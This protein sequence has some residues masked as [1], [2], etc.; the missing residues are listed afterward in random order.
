[1][2]FRGFLNTVNMRTIR[3]TFSFTIACCLL[4]LTTQGAPSDVI[5]V[6]PG[7][8]RPIEVT[9]AMLSAHLKS[10]PE[11][12][13]TSAVQDIVD[14]ALLAQIA[15]ARGLD[16]DAFVQERR[17]EALAWSY[18]KT[19]FEPSYV[20]Q[21]V[22]EAEA[23]AA[24]KA[25]LSRFVHPEVIKASHILIGSPTSKSIE[26]PKDEALASKARELIARVE[27]A[28][29]TKRPISE[30]DFVAAP[31]SIRKDAEALGFVVRGESLGWFALEDGQ[32]DRGFDPGFR[33]ASFPVAVGEVS[34]V[35]ASPFGWHVVRVS[36]RRAAKNE[37]YEMVQSQV[38]LRLVEQVRKRELD[39]LSARLAMQYPAL[40]DR[41]GILRLLKIEPLIRLDSKRVLPTLEK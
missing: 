3:S 17:R 30:E 25:N 2:V 14:T 37:T 4:P 23:R 10:F 40:T 19:V 33:K 20:S 31:E 36:K 27:A 6:A 24:Y 35:F 22:P 39:K 32:F 16:A 21:A 41:E 28:L 38:K 7:L 1:M 5:A 29:K 26:M 8:H 11:Q 13:L 12:A 9:G 15:R 18:L 34:S